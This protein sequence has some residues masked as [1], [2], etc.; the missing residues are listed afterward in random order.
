M[1]TSSPYPP[2]ENPD[3]RQLPPGWSLVLCEHGHKSSSNNLG[4]S[5]RCSAVAPPPLPNYGAPS[6]PPPPGPGSPGYGYNNSPGQYPDTAGPDT[7]NRLLPSNITVLLRHNQVIVQVQ[8]QGTVIERKR[9][10]YLPIALGF[11]NRPSNNTPQQVIYEQAPPKKSG[12]GMGTMLGIGAAGLLEARSLANSSKNHEDNE[13]FDA[14]Q[15]G[16]QDGRDDNYG[17][18][19]GRLWRWRR[20]RWRRRRLVNLLSPTPGPI[21]QTRF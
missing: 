3:R 18:G 16:E 17:G 5:S 12:P 15:Q 10:E 4:S 2:N 8:V 20:L 19:G 21:T 1:S 11:F 6:G 7:S 13:R 14:Y 9:A